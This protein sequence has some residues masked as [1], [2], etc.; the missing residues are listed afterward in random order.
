MT[1]VTSVGE[2]EQKTRLPGSLVAVN[3]L[4]GLLA[5]GGIQGGIA[6]VVNPIGTS[7]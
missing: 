2:L 5:I 3:L 4:L 6:M 7:I 1:V